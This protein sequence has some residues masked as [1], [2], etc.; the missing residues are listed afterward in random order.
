M[1]FS[2][3]QEH[4]FDTILVANR[5]E[6]AVRIL[7]AI[8]VA[9]F[10]SVAIYSAI[11]SQAMHLS[12]ADI[13]VEISGDDLHSTYLNISSIINAAKRTKADA[14][15]PGYGFLSENG[16]F[17]R[18]V[19]EEGL[20]WIGPPP[21]AIDLMGDKLAARRCVLNAGIPLIPGIE[22][23]SALGEHAA[24]DLISSLGTPLM[25]K[26]AAGGGGKGMRR[27]TQLDDIGES[28][29]SA[30]REAQSSFG[31]GR[32]Y[33]EKLLEHSHHVEIQIVADLHGEVAHLLERECSVQRRHQ[34]VIEEAPSPFINVET[35]N[36]ICESAIAV[37]RSVNYVGVGTVE[38]LV[39]QNGDHYFLEMNTRLQVEHPVT[40]AIS[41]VDLVDLQFQIASGSRL[42]PA[43]AGISA[44]GHAMEAR[45]YAESPHNGFLPSTGKIEYLRWPI[46]PGIRI[47]AGV[48][49]GDKIGVTFDPMLAKIIAHGTSREI[50]RRRLIY[51]LKETILL[52]V[53]TNIGFLIDVLE[54]PDQIAGRIDTNW[55]DR[56]GQSEIMP[57][58][59][60]SIAIAAIAFFSK[61]GALPTSRG[62]KGPPQSPFL[63]LSRTYP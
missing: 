61:S 21:S 11:D 31:D 4:F 59:D 27:V 52:G 60:P 17:A 15:H 9:G 28:F 36:A 50:A 6:I 32:I 14:I 43:L 24:I 37:A 8:R 44:K 25:L 30:R 51:A 45:V 7:D 34:K 26:A 49:E 41:G 23:P 16:D 58:L 19:I 42:P 22:I 53:S 40:E 55:I 5:G 54:H 56:L 57:T 48:L 46:G 38:F 35:R 12:H 29:S 18:A 20:V 13:T 63:T 2:V 10:R 62:I 3:S 47:D 33:A 1:S 39:D